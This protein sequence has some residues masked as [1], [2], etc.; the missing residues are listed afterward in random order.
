MKHSTPISLFSFQDIITSLTGILIVVVLIIALE[1][2]DTM[3]TV[4][5]R[6]ELLPDYLCLKQK[7]A[8]LSDTKTALQQ[9]LASND[10]T[11]GPFADLSLPELRDLIAREKR[12][13]ALLAEKT[14][15][16]DQLYNDL[17]IEN[18][19]ISKLSIAVADDM[20]ALAKDDNLIKE[21]QATLLELQHRQ[22]HID[23]LVERKRTMLR[24]SFQGKTSRQPILVEC[25]AW[26]FRARRHPHGALMT[27]G[28]PG[29]QLQDQIPDLCAWL[30][31][32]NIPSC[33]VALL[34]KEGAVAHVS[35]LTSA[36]NGLGPD[37]MLGKE[38]IGAE[39]NC[40]NE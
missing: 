4:A 28:S 18:E 22:K 37:L 6:S 29:R 21:L 19:Q 36:L 25:N 5:A 8:E 32:Q 9:S 26:G 34:I 23:E 39:E 33:Y 10:S 7:A 13:Q 31:T 16:E 14:K 17:V 20:A 38:P 35:E 24:V 40:F 27:F 15:T 30:K 12:Y 3:A 1:L 11:P 2:V